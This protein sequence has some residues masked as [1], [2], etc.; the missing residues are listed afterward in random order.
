MLKGFSEKHKTVSACVKPCLL[1]HTKGVPVGSQGMKQDR[2][3]PQSKILDLRAKFGSERSEGLPANSSLEIVSNF[4]CLVPHIQQE[5]TEM[6]QESALSSLGSAPNKLLTVAP[7]LFQIF[8]K[9]RDNSTGSTLSKH[10]NHAKVT[11]QNK[12]GSDRGSRVCCQTS[13]AK[14]PSSKISLKYSWIFKTVAPFHSPFYLLCCHHWLHECQFRTSLMKLLI[15]YNSDDNLIIIQSKCKLLDLL[16]TKHS[17]HH[18]HLSRTCHQLHLSSEVLTHHVLG[19]APV[20][21][22]QCVQPWGWAH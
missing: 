6:S 12:G 16:H 3:M 15:S 20:R 13:T 7:V 9:D 19:K 4:L 22:K 5:Q 21:N 17:W 1:Y 10:N 2:N 14:T 8:V 18:K 11:C